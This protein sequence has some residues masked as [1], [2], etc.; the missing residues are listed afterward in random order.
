LGE[1]KERKRLR[2]EEV[3]SIAN[4]IGILRSDDA[5]DL[6]KKSFTSQ[7]YFFA[8][9]EARENPSDRKARAVALIYKAMD[10]RVGSSAFRSSA[11][12]T[13]RVQKAA[14]RLSKAVEGVGE[15]I[16]AIDEML[17]ELEDERV[18]DQ[19]WK[20]DCEKFSHKKKQTALKH[21]RSVDDEQATIERKE[22]LI[23]EMNEKIEDAEQQIQELTEA[24][25]TATRNREDEN[26]EFKSNLAD[27]KAAVIL[28][29]KAIG[30]L[31]KFYSDNNLALVQRQEPLVAAGEA[32]A[33]PPSTW[34]GDYGVKKEENNGVVGILELIKE[35]VQKDITEAT[36]AED[37]AQ[38]EYDEFKKNTELD[39]QGQEDDISNFKSTRSDASEA[40]STA[41][42]EKAT[43]LELLQAEVKAYKAKEPDCYFIAVNFHTRAELRVKEVDGLHKAKTIL[44]GGDF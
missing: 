11:K 1:W 3:A 19:E 36:T 8:Q 17:A 16:K 32:P 23:A 13:K 39:I 29:E 7:G 4:A 34:E 10:A 2:T 35:D 21:A 24:L 40:K 38:A 9:M 28:I 25:E 33:P 5:R 12:Q 20:E 6:F 31:G 37:E 22:A 41:E 14:L 15:V 26:A 44:E 27:D 30:A 43:A 42:T 18:N